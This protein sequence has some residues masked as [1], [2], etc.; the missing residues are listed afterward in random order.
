MKECLKNIINV[1]EFPH[2]MCANMC[3]LHFWF[4][5]NNTTYHNIP[6]C[7]RICIVCTCNIGSTPGRISFQHISQ[8]ATY[9][10]SASLIYKNDNSLW[11]LFCVVTVVIL[12]Q[13]SVKSVFVS[14]VINHHTSQPP[15]AAFQTEIFTCCGNLKFMYLFC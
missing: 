15:A 8:R 11:L 5:V 10:C 9:N 3:A 1:P 14:I 2:F 13:Y 12:P 7:R 6:T 4:D